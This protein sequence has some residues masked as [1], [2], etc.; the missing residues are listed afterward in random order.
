[1]STDDS[2]FWITFYYILIAASVLVLG[3]IRDFHYTT[4]AWMKLTFWCWPIWV[5]ILPIVGVVKYIKS[6]P[7]LWREATWK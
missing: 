7:K 6:I 5:V 1:M 3:S 2:I 4:R